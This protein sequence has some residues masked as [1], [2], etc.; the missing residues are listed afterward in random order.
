MAARP[1]IAEL[2]HELQMSKKGHVYL[3]RKL[4]NKVQVS[5]HDFEASRRE[6]ADRTARVEKMKLKVS[7]WQKSL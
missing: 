6:L 7:Y 5:P 1:F 3:A 4:A 2:G